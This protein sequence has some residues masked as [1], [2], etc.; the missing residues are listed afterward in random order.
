MAIIK[1]KEIRTK[2]NMT[3]IELEKLSGISRSTIS[4]IERG[5]V[6]P[7]IYELECIA[8]A[9]E[10]NPYDLFKFTKN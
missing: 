7:T 4:R 2:K 6:S 9:L 10:I 8:K 3:L 5:K 1:L